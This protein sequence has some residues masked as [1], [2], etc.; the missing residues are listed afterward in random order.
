M[1]RSSRPDLVAAGGGAQCDPHNRRYTGNGASTRPW[2][3][4]SSP[5]PSGTR[6]SP[7]V[8]DGPGVIE[9]SSVR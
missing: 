2:R 3:N 8:A 5:R 1:M 4:H 6:L 9:V 7:G